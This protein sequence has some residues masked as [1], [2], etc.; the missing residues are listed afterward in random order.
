M[1]NHDN[2]YRFNTIARLTTETV[3]PYSSRATC[4]G[5]AHN[6]YVATPGVDKDKEGLGPSASFSG[7]IMTSAY[8]PSRPL[9]DRRRVD[10]DTGCP[11]TSRCALRVLNGS[12]SVEP[13]LM[14]QKL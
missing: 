5:L 2:K 12:W 13:K 14:E 6:T 10:E 3:T 11:W 1:I 9:N 7:P 8:L 4:T